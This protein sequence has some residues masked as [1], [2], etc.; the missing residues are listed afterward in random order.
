MQARR[1]WDDIFKV[2]KEKLPTNILYPAKLSFKTEEKQ[3]KKYSGQTK[4]EGVHHHI[5]LALKEMLKRIIQ[6]ET[7]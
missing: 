6:A 3:K 1:K 7:K 2:P 5:P 4:T